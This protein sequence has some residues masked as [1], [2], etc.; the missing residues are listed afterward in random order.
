MTAPLFE[1]IAEDWRRNAFVKTTC[2]VMFFRIASF[3]AQ[4]DR[5]TRLAGAPLIALYIVMVD[6]IMGIEIPV[7]T[8]IGKGFT[9]YHGTGTVINGYCTLGARCVMRHG[10]TI[11]NLLDA[12]GA[13]GGVPS[14]G[15]DVEFGAHCTVLGAIRIGDRARIG[16]GAVVLCDV[17]DDGVAVGV[18]ARVLAR[19]RRIA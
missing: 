9:L 5:I 19:P 6:W 17:P 13:P 4:R 14:I 8:H 10:V 2:V 15:D 1:T 7:G 18:P 11:G 12:D 3:L 16:A